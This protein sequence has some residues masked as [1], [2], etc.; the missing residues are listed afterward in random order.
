[1]ILV[2]LNNYYLVN[3]VFRSICSRYYRAPE[4]VFGEINCTTKIVDWHAACVLA[5]L[6][7]GKPIFPGDSG[8]DQLMEIIKVLCTLN[9]EQIRQMIPKYTK[10]KLLPIKSR[11][12]QKVFR[13]RTL[14]PK[15]YHKY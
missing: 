14:L 4:L 10:F 11:S 7:L 15:P 13:A 6:L 12:W 1:V 9:S 3:R 5:E 8:V 2:L